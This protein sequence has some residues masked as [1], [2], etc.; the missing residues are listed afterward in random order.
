[1][2]YSLIITTCPDRASAQTLGRVL[3]ERQLV[4]CAQLSDIESIYAWK[5][6]IEQEKEVRVM[7]KTRS[8]LYGRVEAAIRENHPYEVPQIVRLDMDASAAYGLWM[9]DVTNPQ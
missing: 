1:M 3:V 9:D 6:G 5:G 2:P 8:A 4:A 7:L